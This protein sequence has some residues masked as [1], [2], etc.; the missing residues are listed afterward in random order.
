VQKRLAAFYSINI[1]ANGFGSILAYGCMQLSG[2]NGWLGWRWIF[3]VNGAMTMVLAILGRLLIVDFPDKVHKARFP[4]LKPAEVKAIQDKLERDRHDAEF[5]EIT[6][7]KFLHALA[8]WQLWVFA[9]KF[10]A[11]TTIVYALAFFIPIILQ[12]M[13]YSVGRVFL[14]SAPPAIAAVPWVMLCSWAADRY[15]MRA[16]FII[17]QALIGI[18]GLM[19][20][21]YSKNNSA[22]YFGIFMGLAGANANIPTALAWQANNIRGQSLRM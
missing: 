20:V 18:V 8:K 4:F 12:G 13:G 17:L 1:I 15:K 19:I 22:R 2:R 9:M 11:V 10:F 5:D 6:G 3:I 16:P 14:L 21:A 7:G